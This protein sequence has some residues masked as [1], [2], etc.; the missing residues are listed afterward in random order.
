LRGENRVGGTQTPWDQDRHEGR[1]RD[2]QRPGDETN[3][4]HRQ[5]P[6]AP[7][8]RRPNPDDI[9]YGGWD[10]ID[11]LTVDQCANR[12]PGIHTVEVIPNSLLTE[13]TEAWNTAHKMRQAARTYED[14]EKALKWILWLP[15][16]LLYAPQRGGKNGARQYK[17]LARRFVMWRQ[18]DMLGLVKTWKMAAVTAKKRLSKA[19]ARKAKGDQARVARAIRLLRRGAISR[20][21]HALESKGLGD[22]DNPEIWEHLQKKHPD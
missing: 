21:G 2:E 18:K 3:P 12:P 15:Q 13:W 4:R 16:G 8:R 19:G 5:F 9:A 14:N 20:A 7:R 22:L 10:V 17:E 1:T 6:E 11:H